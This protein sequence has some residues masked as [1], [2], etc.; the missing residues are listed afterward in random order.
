M[1]RGYACYGPTPCTESAWDLYWLVVHPAAQGVGLGRLLLD[2]VAEA[3]RSEGGTAL[4]A[5]TAGKPAYAPTRAFYARTGFQAV[6]TIPD[7][8]ARGDAKL[9]LLHPLE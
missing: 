4:Y 9:I 8:Y 6:A 3:V 7:F 1:L 2:R 5:E